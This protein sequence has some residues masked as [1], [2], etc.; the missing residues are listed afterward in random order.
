LGKRVNAI[1]RD[2][3]R[4]VN[5]PGYLLYEEYLAA[6]LPAGRATQ[7]EIREESARASH[8]PKNCAMTL[9]DTLTALD[10]RAIL[11][12]LTSW[13][14]GVRVFDGETVLIEL[15]GIRCH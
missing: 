13:S 15:R 14:P 4:D 12:I 1:L 7:A 5:A 9:G 2:F 11:F 3:F 8:L 10:Y 6:T